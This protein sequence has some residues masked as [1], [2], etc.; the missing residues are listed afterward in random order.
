M[1][2]VGK[3]PRKMFCFLYFFAF[4]LLAVSF[5]VDFLW[6]EKDDDKKMKLKTAHTTN[7]TPLSL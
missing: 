6:N 4:A 7:K 2:S 3:N 1:L 5:G